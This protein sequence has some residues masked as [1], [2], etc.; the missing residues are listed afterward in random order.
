MLSAQQQGGPAL[1]S[2][3]DSSCNRLFYDSHL[4]ELLLSAR[5]QGRTLK[6]ATLAVRKSP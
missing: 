6:D 5:F 4:R 3:D 1:L 2:G